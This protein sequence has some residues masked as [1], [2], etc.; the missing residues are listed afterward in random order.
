MIRDYS[1]AIGDRDDDERV[2]RSAR[3]DE[4]TKW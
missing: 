1:E 4:L 3:N 2:E